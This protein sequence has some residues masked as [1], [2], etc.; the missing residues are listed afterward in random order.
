[1]KKIVIC[2]KCLG[3]N[4]LKES[5]Y[6]QL[7]GRCGAV[8]YR[9]IE[10]LEFKTASLSFSALIFYAAAVSMPLLSIEIN[11][12]SSQLSVFDSV[13]LLSESGY[14]LISLIA[15]LILILFP[16]L[17]SSALFLFSLFKLSGSSKAKE[18]LKLYTYLRK[19]SMLDIFLISA[20]VALVKI[21]D[22]AFIEIDIA[23][24]ALVVF[25]VIETYLTKVIKPEYLW[26]LLDD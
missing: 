20:I 18:A 8:I 14:V 17:N 24:G 5:P 2:E 11:G 4:L 13:S 3:K 15:F 6:T 12:K 19:W 9:K 7:C 25:V 1:M 23:F 10:A 22:Y 26:E 16:F 21:S